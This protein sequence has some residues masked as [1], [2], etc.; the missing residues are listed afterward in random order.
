MTKQN[1]SASGSDII[2]KLADMELTKSIIQKLEACIDRNERNYNNA[3]EFQADPIQ[4]VKSEE[5]KNWITDRSRE[6][7]EYRQNLSEVHSDIDAV[8]RQT[9]SYGDLARQVKD[10]LQEN[11]KLLEYLK[12]EVDTP[13]QEPEPTGLK[14]LEAEFTAWWTSRR[15]F[16]WRVGVF[17]T[18]IV[19]AVLVSLYFSL[20]SD[21]AWS[22]RAYDA[23]VGVG[24]DHPENLYQ[25]AR[26]LFG[27]K[28]RE[29][30]KEIILKYESDMEALSK[31]KEVQQ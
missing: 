31:E 27:K 30:V 20:W 4:V 9:I 17:C 15:V 13:A 11:V 14:K 25:K 23:A 22:R 10:V 8:R 26:V 29:E 18:T 5:I 7:E 21:D 3:M 28:E 12:R 1:I 16:W 2:P 19:A 24:Y 6:Y